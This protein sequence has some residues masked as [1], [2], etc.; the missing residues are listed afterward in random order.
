MTTP[1]ADWKIPPMPRPSSKGILPLDAASRK[2]IPIGTGVIDYFPDALIEVARVSE[3]GNQQH[4]PGQPLHWAKGKSTDHA[5]TMMRHF[6]ERFEVD[7]D[8][9]RHAAKMCWRALAF[10]QTLIEEERGNVG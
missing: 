8:G 1:P 6:I 2:A 4:N 3:R 7:Q 5:D 10:L 9:Q